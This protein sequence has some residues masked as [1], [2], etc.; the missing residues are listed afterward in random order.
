M[1]SHHPSLFTLYN[2]ALSADEIPRQYDVSPFKSCVI[3]LSPSPLPSRKKINSFNKSQRP[4][5]PFELG[6]PGERLQFTA[7]NAGGRKEVPTH[8]RKNAPSWFENSRTSLETF[9]PVWDAKLGRYI[10]EEQRWRRKRAAF[11]RARISVLVVIVT[12][13]EKNERDWWKFREDRGR[14]NVEYF[15]LRMIT[16]R[17][18]SCEEASLTRM[19]EWNFSCWLEQCVRLL[20]ENCIYM[21]KIQKRNRENVKVRCLGRIMVSIVPGSWNIWD[22]C[23]DKEIFE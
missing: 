10:A 5:N 22:I 6:K 4:G 9:K 18:L 7:V 14:L 3:F 11:M 13:R 16:L 17:T 8:D 19:N 1:R 20:D 21:V 23:V 12:L 15:V 2:P